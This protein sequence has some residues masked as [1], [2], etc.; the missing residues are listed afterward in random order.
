MS[1]QRSPRLGENPDFSDSEIELLERLMLSG[2]GNEPQAKSMIRKGMA[3]YTKKDGTVVQAYDREEA[4]KPMF[5][6]G[7]VLFWERTAPG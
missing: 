1:I 3:G 4:R 7:E 6:N 5:L 2:S